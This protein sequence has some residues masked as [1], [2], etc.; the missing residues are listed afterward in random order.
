MKNISS[1]FQALVLLCSKLNSCNC[2]WEC[3]DPSFGINAFVNQPRNYVSPTAPFQGLVQKFDI[4]F[5]Y[6][7]SGAYFNC[8]DQKKG[9]PKKPATA[10][11]TKPKKS[12]ASAATLCSPT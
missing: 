12:Q 3:T 6:K 4:I 11:K 1:S 7:A 10:A 9:P 8:N 5:S 2:I